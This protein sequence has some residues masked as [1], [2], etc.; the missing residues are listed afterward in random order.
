MKSL[1]CFALTCLLLALAA[2][3]ATAQPLDF[4][5]P[6][7]DGAVVKEQLSFSTHVTSTYQLQ[8]VTVSVGGLSQALMN[9]GQDWYGTLDLHTLASGPYP[10]VVRAVDVLANAREK[11]ISIRLNRPSPRWRMSRAPTSR[12]TRRRTSIRST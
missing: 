5:M 1:S 10:L 4:S 2:P 3:A 7:Q 8:S 12:G 9:S 11:R 6:L